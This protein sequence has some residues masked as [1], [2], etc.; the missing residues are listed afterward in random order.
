MIDLEDAV[1]EVPESAKDLFRRP[2]L[3]WATTV[4][5]DGTPHNTVVWVD[6]DDKGEIVFNTAVGRVKERH[7]RANPS[8]ALSVLDPENPYHYVTVNGTAEITTEGALDTINRLA[9]K[10][11]N[12]DTYP[13]L[14]PGEVRV[15]VYVRPERVFYNNPS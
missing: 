1:A 15:N 8:I 10:Y 5:A 14:Q 2:N 13:N 12:R 11:I 9:K 4:R 3:A 7:L 6:V